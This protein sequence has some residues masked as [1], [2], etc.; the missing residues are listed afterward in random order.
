MK[1]GGGLHF[2]GFVGY[3]ATEQRL[4]SLSHRVLVDTWALL[5]VRKRNV[6]LEKSALPKCLRLSGDTTLP[7]LQIER[8]LGGSVWFGVK[9]ER[10]VAPPLLS[11]NFYIHSQLLEEARSVRPHR[12]HMQCYQTRTSPL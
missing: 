1:E 2:G 9:S 3:S 8:A 11:V 4:A 12:G 7:S 6:Q 10:V 5:T